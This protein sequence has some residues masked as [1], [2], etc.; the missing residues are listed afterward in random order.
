MTQRAALGHDEERF[1]HYRALLA[2]G[3]PLRDGLDRIV[4]GRTGALV[5]LGNNAAVKELSTGGFTVNTPF[6]PTALRELAK[7]DGGI[8]VS[9]HIETIV[10]AGVHFVPSG[11][12]PT[13]ETGTRHRT[14]DRIAQQA[15]VPVVTVSAAMGTIA[16]FME[17]LRY[18]IEQ[19]SAIMLQAD[20]ALS[21]LA[22]Y[23]E[24]LT[25][26]MR[27]LSALELEDLVTLR[28][29]IGAAQRVEMLRRLAN[30]IEGYVEALG[31][32]G[33]LLQLQMF[34]LTSGV[35]QIATLLEYDYRP[36]GAER[37]SFSI[38]NLRHLGTG[39]LLDAHTV[40]STIGFGNA[41]L[42]S[43]VVTRGFR[44]MSNAT[45]MSGPMAARLIEHFGSLSSLM[46]AS[47][48][49][50]MEVE[51]IGEARARSLRD[52][53]ARLSDQALRER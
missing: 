22:R 34:E 24:R 37:S 11:E 4:S 31:V 5:V 18:P 32:E 52:G 35:D 36:E 23:R 14:A 46:G 53:F 2:P 40:A 38:D 49:D 29:V 26:E 6:T 17:G 21:T 1:R 10:A 41:A 47:M 51:G 44:Q 19:S 27:T 13:I 28:D 12:V 3:T 42:D 20:Q 50:L 16:L 48:N 30:E 25:E 15:H 8:V 33:R 43:H 9:D 45:Q 39:D 7:M